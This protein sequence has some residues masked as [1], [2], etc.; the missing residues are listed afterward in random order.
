[1]K[2]MDLLEV[3]G[4]IR[5]KYILEAGKC[6]EQAAPVKKAKFTRTVQI[7][8][9]A[10]IAL[11]LAGI[12]FLQTPLG[13][14]AVEIVKESISRL[15]E[16]LF[17]PKD[18][19]V[20]PEGTPEVVHHEAQGRDPAEESPG[21]VMYVDTENY[22]MTQENDAFYVRQI[23]IEYDREAIRDQQAALLEGLSPEEQEAAIDARIQELKDFYAALPA[24]EIEIREI[25]NKEFSAYAEEVR[26][27]MSADWKV[28]S[29]ILWVDKPLADTFSVSGGDQWNSPQEDHYFVDNGKQGTFHIVARYYLEAAEG[30][31]MRFMSMIQTFEVVTN[32]QT[33][34]YTGGA[35]DVLEAMQQ[36]VTAAAKENEAMLLSAQQDSLS[37]ADTAE[38]AKQ[39]YHLWLDT[40]DGLWTALEQKLDV[41]TMEDLL[42]SQL[43]WSVRKA[44]EQDCAAA[45]VE[46]EYQSAAVF[47]GAGADLLEQR[48][49]YLL[50]VLE[51][52]AP[53][54]Q[55]DSSVQ[56]SPEG[57]VSQFIKAYYSG[58]KD[59]VIAF[60]SESY[61]WDWGVDVYTDFAAADPSINAIKGLD[62]LIY[63]MADRGELHP[64]VEFRKTPDSDYY[65]YLSISLAWED[66]RWKVSFYA[67]EG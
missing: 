13:V 60:L 48:V 37:Q 25:P 17:P 55:Q 31:G 9:A 58:D 6:R 35:E 67:L 38:I 4:S 62:H 27:Q 45:A 51:G 2:S 14:A 40:L 23:P 18:I 8:I 39:R 33:D 30:H 59:A 10:M 28:T 15:I 42:I 56:L 52:T 50:N 20:M 29:D 12:L 46:E 22:V 16:T 5:D 54:Q 26:N 65:I 3:V 7:R 41:E 36:Q 32:E 47:Y 34:Q 57:I 66:N 61:P 53:V 24:N 43:E 64:S 21:F 63:D 1:M 44:A 19:I 49:Y 11:V